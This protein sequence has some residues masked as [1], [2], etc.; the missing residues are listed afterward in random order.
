[1]IRTRL[2]LGGVVQGVG[3]RPFIYRLA[4]A[5]SLAGFIRNHAG[6]VEIEL[7]G[8]ASA[9]AQFRIRLE[10]E[11][12]PHATPQ[13]LSTTPLSSAGAQEFIIAPSAPGPAIPTPDLALCDD[14][15]SDTDNP[16]NRRHLYPFTSC[17]NC[18]PR[19]SIVHSL[20]F[21]RARTSMRDFPQCDACEAE[22]AD[23]SNRRFHAQTNACP[24]CGPRL[25]WC[26]AAGQ[27]LAPASVL[28][29]A[30]AALRQGATIAL[31][32]LAGFQLLTLAS[33]HAAVARLRTRKSRPRKPFA[34]MAPSLAAAE[35][36]A[37]ITPTER[38]FLTSPAAPIVL[39][40]AKPTAAIATNVAPANPYL[41]LMLPSTPLHHLLLRELKAPI[42]ATS[43]NPPG[44][45]IIADNAEALRDLA[46]IADFFLLHDRDIIHPA[47]DSVLLITNNREQ[48]LR[49]ARGFAPLPIPHPSIT[50][51]ILALGAQQKSALAVAAF[52]QI[53][54][55]PHIGDLDTPAARARLAAHIATFPA[56]LGI[57]PE[58]VACDLHPD[59]A[60][61]RAARQTSLPLT[62]VPHHLAHVLS[63]MAEHRLSP[64]LLGV[65]WD[66]TGLGTDGTIWGGEFLALDGPT[67]HRAAHLLPFRL[68]GAE[69]AIREPRRAALGVL[70]AI[71]GDSAHSAHFPRAEHAI[72]SAMLTSGLQSPLTTSAGRLFDAAASLLGLCQRSSFEGEAAMA[73]EFAALKSRISIALPAAE[74]VNH[75][76]RLIIDW[77]PTL[78]ALIAASHHGVPNLAAAFHEA[79]AQAILAVALRLGYNR[80]L[81]TGGCFQNRI[82]TERTTKLLR[83]AGLT[84]YSSHQIPCNDGG[85]A[86]GQIIFAASPMNEENP[87]VPGNPRTGALDRRR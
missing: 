21:D 50:R 32:G 34:V 5:H 81:L 37:T 42:V 72:L 7:E 66:G 17:T 51:P 30:A 78:A 86:V 12:P 25:T 62:H 75:Q 68:P 26:D 77:R 9:I 57:T 43:G 71:H 53:F 79:L 84:P 6:G 22:Y 20:P 60:S 35:E 3:F 8:P 19:F 29:A 52:G 24:A 2:T 47:D 80:I 85:L 36:L 58:A 76:D 46:P 14:C 73:L 55:A 74:L 69:A 16:A 11:S 41:G 44:A 70:H 64:P 18:G 4:R 61:T 40:R 45:P 27:T 48:I 39:L 56:L 49:R 65:V 83:E 23:P 63:A 87:H 31:K 1:M 13:I 28:A 10:T 82:L 15:K 38:A 54:P 33:N 67:Y 59:Y